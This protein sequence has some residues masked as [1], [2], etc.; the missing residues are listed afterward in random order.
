[1]HV[2]EGISY[3]RLSGSRIYSFHVLSTENTLRAYHI[4]QVQMAIMEIQSENHP[5]TII[6]YVFLL[7]SVHEIEHTYMRWY[8]IGIVLLHMN[9]AGCIQYIWN[10]EQCA[11]FR[12]QTF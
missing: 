6:L 2:D 7:Y 8:D 4:L 3:H 11:Q 12:R 9:Q 10:G 1:M 5:F